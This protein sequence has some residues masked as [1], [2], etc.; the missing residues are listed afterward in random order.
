[1]GQVLAADLAA[2][3]KLKPEIDELASELKAKIPPS[4]AAPHG[5]DPAIAAMHSLL[6]DTLAE[7]GTVLVGWMG[8]LGDV[9]AAFQKGLVL[10][11]E[12][13]TAAMRAV[14]SP[15]HS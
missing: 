14:G 7:V 4:S 1:M 6:S 15:L 3:G 13:G 10:T 2:L 12:Q 11:E 8:A 5:A 9:T